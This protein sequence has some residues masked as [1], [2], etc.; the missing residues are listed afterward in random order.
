M[1]SLVFGCLVVLSFA[2]LAVGPS[3]DRRS[4]QEFNVNDIWRYCDGFVPR[5][6][7]DVEIT[8]TPNPPKAGRWMSVTVS[9]NVLPGND[10]GD[11]LIQTKFLLNNLIPFAETRAYC[12]N[13]NCPVQPGKFSTTIRYFVLPFVSGFATGVARVVEKGSD[14]PLVC[15]HIGPVG[16][17]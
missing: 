15:V 4:L 2:A 5:L 1:R 11:P 8:I 16:I 10:I 6:F 9:A 13:H 17:S 12:D 3:A 14:E 7:D